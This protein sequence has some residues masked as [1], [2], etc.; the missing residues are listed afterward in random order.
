MVKEKLL[1]HLQKHRAVDRPIAD[2]I[3]ACD[4]L[5]E[6]DLFGLILLSETA[7]VQDA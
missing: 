3:T 2:K 6:V 1:L 7:R 4:L 5:C